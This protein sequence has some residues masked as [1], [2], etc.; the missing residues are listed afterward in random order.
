[1]GEIYW[2]KRRAWPIASLDEKVGYNTKIKT[3][4][5]NFVLN[6]YRMAKEKKAEKPISPDDELFLKSSIKKEICRTGKTIKRSRT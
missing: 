6:R 3:A 2:T 4:K 5:P 1:M